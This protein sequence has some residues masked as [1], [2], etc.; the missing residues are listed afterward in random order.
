[1]SDIVSKEKRSEIMSKIK[2]KDTQIELMV[3]E[4][5]DYLGIDYTRYNKDVF[6]N[7][8]FVIR[9]IKTAIFVHGCFWHQHEGC[10]YAY[11]PKSN[12]KFW[13]SKFNSNKKRDKLVCEKLKSEGWKVIIVW[14]CEVKEGSFREK[15]YMEVGNV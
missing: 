13:E 3:A 4:Y 11:K 12:I 5:L 15:L 1:M 2:S 8:D 10:K 14:E 7:P 9:V 6:G